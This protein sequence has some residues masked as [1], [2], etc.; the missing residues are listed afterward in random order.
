MISRV[1][2]SP[3]LRAH[4][5]RPAL[6]GGRLVASSSSPEEG[7]SVVGT[8]LQGTASDG[9]AVE[10]AICGAEASP[11]DPEVTWYRIKAW[12]ELAQEWENPCVSLNG[13]PASHALVPQRLYRLH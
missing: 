9:R 3:R 8:V 11:E 6:E 10:V 1:P 4:P 12:N 13:M 2:G 5:F 7:T